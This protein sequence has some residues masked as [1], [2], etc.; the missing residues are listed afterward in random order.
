MEPAFT[1][2]RSVFTSWFPF[3]FVCLF[4]CTDLVF[5]CRQKQCRPVSTGRAWRKLANNGSWVCLG[6]IEFEFYIE[7][8]LFAMEPA[9]TW[10][11]SVFTSWFPFFFVWFFSAKTLCL[12]VAKNSAIHFSHQVFYIKC[13]LFAME[14]AFTW[15]YQLLLVDF[16]FFAIN[17]HSFYTGCIVLYFNATSTPSWR[18]QQDISMKF[19]I[20]YLDA[21]HNRYTIKTFRLTEVLHCIECVDYTLIYVSFAFKITIEWTQLI[22]HTITAL[23]V[24]TMSRVHCNSISHRGMEAFRS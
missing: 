2:S 18:G 16:L 15:F 23:L 10:S 20:V 22:F 8:L 24:S 17:F 21:Y 3:F 6:S 14:H 13:L 19:I 9:F 1:W 11:R 7:C 12:N 4:F 5:E